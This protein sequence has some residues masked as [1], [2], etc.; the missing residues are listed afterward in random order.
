MI[1]GLITAME[2]ELKPFFNYFT[3]YKKET[4]FQNHFYF[5]KYHQHEI[6]LMCCGRGKVNATIF[7]A[8]MI[9]LYKPELIINCG[10]SGGI[11]VDSHI[12][13]CYIGTEYCHYDVRKKQS[14]NTFPH[15]LYYQGD[16]ETVAKILQLNDSV[17]K[18]IFGTGENFVS[19]EEDKKYIAEEFNVS[20][21]DM[22][23]AAIAQCCYIKDTKFISLRTICDKADDQAVFTEESLQ[24]KASEKYTEIILKLIE[25]I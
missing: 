14:K 8:D 5:C 3:V 9:Q 13:D 17:K 10:V 21:V 18:G 7:T 15:Q 6:I 11:A 24:E 2:L 16:K 4:T 20:A 1:I 19:N 22:E 12:F 23:S 25:H